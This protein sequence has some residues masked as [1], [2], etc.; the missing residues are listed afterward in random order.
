MVARNVDYMQ[1]LGQ[2]APV[3]KACQM[4]L[5]ISQPSRPNQAIRCRVT[6][7]FEDY[8]GDVGVRRWMISGWGNILQ[9][10]GRRKDGPG[11]G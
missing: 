1:N 11:K 5:S 7:A 4:A 9:I 2:V 10:C 8:V 3:A 6:D